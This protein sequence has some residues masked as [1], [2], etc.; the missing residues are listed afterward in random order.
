MTGSQNFD[1]LEVP[2]DR[3]DVGASSLGHMPAGPWAFDESVTE[4][5]DDMLQRS[6]PQYDVMRATIALLARDF[7][8]SG[9]LVVDLGA[10]SGAGIAPLVEEER[11]RKSGAPARFVAIECSPSML[12]ELRERFAAPGDLGL[13]TVLDHDLRQGLPDLGGPASLILSVLTLQFVPMEYR[14]QVIR[15]AY[16]ALAPGGAM[17]LVEK[18]L[19]TSA[20][21]DTQFAGH[22]LDYKRRNGYS[23][24]EIDRKRLSLEGVLV[25]VTARWNEE[26]L[27]HAGFSQIDCFWRWMNFAGWLALKN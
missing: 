17:I 6:I 3:P 23:A 14:Q 8:R 13:V 10:S 5:F 16:Q 19:G 21:L 15:S 22:Y 9:E 26:M 1:D 18:V 4:V 24:E 20:A 2:P 27:Q 12:K 11:G 25:P 7:I